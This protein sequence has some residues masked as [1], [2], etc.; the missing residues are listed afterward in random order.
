MLTRV[1]TVLAALCMLSACDTTR[2]LRELRS[3]T[4]TGD[5]YQQALAANYRELAEEKEKTYEWEASKYFA[6]KGLMV[7]YGRDIEPEDAAQWNIPATMQPEFADARGKL[8]AAIAANR[9]TQPE[10]SASAVLAYDRWV[11]L[12]HYGW[13]APA[14]EEQRDIFFAILAKLEEAQAAN[15]TEVPTTTIPT[16][17]TS[18]VLYF[19]L[20]S[21]H[22]GD[23]ALAALSELVRYVKSAGNVTISINGHTDRAGTAEFNMNLSQ[24]RARFV[25]Q[26]LIK[27]GVS[28]SII[29]YFAFGETDPAVATEDGVKEPKNRRVEIYIE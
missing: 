29:N 5:D 10:M 26:A 9:S 25:M 2:S 3:L 22:L 23:T 21:D 8:M 13:N 28:E 11:E 27:A 24:R 14:I 15:P 6:D 16:E 20:N 1:L 12:Q 4:P 17:S 18:T 7:A 19:P